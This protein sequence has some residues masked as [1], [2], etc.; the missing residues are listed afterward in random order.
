VSLRGN[1][2]L[3][4][5]EELG[6]SQAELAYSDLL[7]PEAIANWPRTLGRDG[8][9]TPMPWK[10]SSPHSGFTTGAPWLPVSAAH[11]LLAVDG[12][13]QDPES[14]LSLTRR[15][16]ALRRQHEALRTGGLHF[17]DAAEPLLAFERTNGDERLLCLFNL[18][19]SAAGWSPGGVDTWHI[20]ER[21]GGAN[22]EHLPPYSGLIAAAQGEAP[23][24]P[25]EA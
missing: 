5:G 17:L 24:E 19:A 8:A 21:V 9:R 4:Q 18:G 14:Q 2:F 22:W 3:Y 7:D 13:E 15:L 1:I 23:R 10:S 6:L 16:L 11:A 20:L 25:S 12:Q